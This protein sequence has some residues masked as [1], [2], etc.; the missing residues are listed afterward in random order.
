MTGTVPGDSFDRDGLAPD[1]P[2]FPHEEFIPAGA[3]LPLVGPAARTSANLHLPPL[4]PPP[5]DGRYH[6]DREIARGAMGVV[7]RGRDADF[8]RDVA[9]KVL[10]DEHL[11]KPDLCRRFVDEARI[12]ARLQH[13]GIVPIY[14]VGEFPGGRPYYAMRLV[15]GQTLGELLDA[16]ADTPADRSR[17]LKVF[18]T[19]CAALAYAHAA[20]VIHRDLKPANVMVAPFGM[21]KVMDWGVAKVLAGGRFAGPPTADPPGDDRPPAAGG[22]GE[23]TQHGRVL[24]TPQYMSPE[25]AGGHIDR[26]DER[27]DVFGLGGILCTILT[28]TPPYAGADARAVYRKA[29]AA[30]LAEP[31]ARLDG[32]GADPELVALCKRCLAADPVA[33]PRDAGVLAEELT[34]Y[35]DYDLRR[36]ERDLVRFFELSPD[37]FCIAGLDGF[38][39]RVNPNF[40]RV[41][42]YTTEELLARP[43]VE[44]V[45]PDDRA[46]TADVMKGLSAG[47]PC[48]RFRNRYRDLGGEYRWFEWAAK[49]IPEE[50]VVFAVA[51]DVTDQVTLENQV[52]FYE[53]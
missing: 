18:E 23:Q 2:L 50:G 7:Y 11:R 9:V 3:T 8:G 25:Q 32:C 4:P 22:D 45:H 6:L 29:V 28:G 43:F 51:R 1:D 41:L 33:R 5:T 27:T 46:R 21:V 34:E 39:Y 47:V 20:G 10:R 37:L 53:G 24:G 30:E 31:F 16:R 52:R 44:F 42:G 38:F 49:P 14:A 15:D 12:T 40:A 13:P 36:T 26:L 35:L 17:F 19:V 48:V